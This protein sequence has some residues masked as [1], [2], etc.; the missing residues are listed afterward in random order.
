MSESQQIDIASLQRVLH[1][2]LADFGFTDQPPATCPPR[3]GDIERDRVAHI[4]QGVIH[5]LRQRGV[6]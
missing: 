1:C 5:E 6:L 4:A 3:S 2:I